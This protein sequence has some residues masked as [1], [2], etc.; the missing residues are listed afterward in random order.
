[1]AITER[2]EGLLALS[3]GARDASHRVQGSLAPQRINT[4]R[5]NSDE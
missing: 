2:K 3:G 5:V 1:M 4:L